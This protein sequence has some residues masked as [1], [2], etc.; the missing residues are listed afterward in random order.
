MKM[1]KTF[2]VFNGLRRYGKGRRAFQ[3]PWILVSSN[4]MTSKNVMV[5]PFSPFP[6]RVCGPIPSTEWKYNVFYAIYKA[7]Y[8]YYNIYNIQLHDSCTDSTV[9]RQLHDH[10]GI[11]SA[12]CTII[13][14]VAQMHT[15]VT[16]A[17]RQSS[18]IARVVRPNG[19]RNRTQRTE[20]PPKTLSPTFGYELIGGYPVKRDVWAHGRS[21]GRPEC[22]WLQLHS[23]CTLPS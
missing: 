19:H 23:S 9:A 12:N 7:I 2:V 3:C 8:I 22:N 21:V 6:W 20:K 15:S 5:C 14:T 16:G 11:Y 4:T 1:S 10:S 13:P 18:P 17:C